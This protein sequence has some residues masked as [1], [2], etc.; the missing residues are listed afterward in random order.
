MCV[1]YIYKGYLFAIFFVTLR[2][3]KEEGVGNR[4]LINTIYEKSSYSS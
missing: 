3:V 4:D 1:L 2:C